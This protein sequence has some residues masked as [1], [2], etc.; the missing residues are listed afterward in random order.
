MRGEVGEERGGPSYPNSIMEVSWEQMKLMW[1]ELQFLSNRSPLRSGSFNLDSKWTEYSV[2]FTFSNKLSNA[3]KWWGS[4]KTWDNQ[5]EPAAVSNASSEAGGK[6]RPCDW[7]ATFVQNEIPKQL[8]FGLPDGVVAD[9][10]LAYNNHIWT[11]F[12]RWIGPC[13]STIH[14]SIYLTEHFKI[15]FH[16]L[17]HT[18]WPQIPTR[19][20]MHGKSHH[21]CCLS[22]HS[23]QIYSLTVL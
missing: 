18:G 21:L 2:C 11:A 14:S 7:S 22:L 6:P 4:F 9:F 23:N 10:N 20:K 3:S 5:L 12:T 19:V 17:F 1:T 8:L 15:R 16:F 13:F